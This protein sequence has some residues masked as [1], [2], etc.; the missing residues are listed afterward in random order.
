M[1]FSE[2]FQKAIYDTI[3]RYDRNECEKISKHANIDKENIFESMGWDANHRITEGDVAC[4]LR[5]ISAVAHQKI[6]KDFPF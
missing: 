2:A 4:V 5:A 1:N 3:T 6:E